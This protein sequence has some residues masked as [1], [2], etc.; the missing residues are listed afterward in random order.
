L[1]AI[2]LCFAAS[3]STNDGVD[4][5]FF[6]KDLVELF[7]RVFIVLFFWLVVGN[8]RKMHL[9]IQPTGNHTRAPQGM[10]GL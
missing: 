7:F 4:R 6:R 8:K 3:C 10:W 9:L 5:I 1:A 2:V